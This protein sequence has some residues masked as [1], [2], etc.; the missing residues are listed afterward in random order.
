MKMSFQDGPIFKRS[1]LIGRDSNVLTF[2]SLGT[3]VDTFSMS[4]LKRSKCS[5][6]NMR[7][8]FSEF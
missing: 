5:M 7:Y 4:D 3:L 2:E 6:E 8:K 1:Y